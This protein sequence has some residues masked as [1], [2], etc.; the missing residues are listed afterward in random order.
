MSQF[1]WKNEDENQL[2]INKNKKIKNNILIVYVGFAMMIGQFLLKC[3]LNVEIKL[4]LFILTA[5][6]QQH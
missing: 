4:N 5:D 3:N 6:K 1:Y 2:K